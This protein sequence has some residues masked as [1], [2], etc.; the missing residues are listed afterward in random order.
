MNID[1]GQ[2]KAFATLT[3]S[4]QG[5]LYIEKLLR[6]IPRGGTVLEI[7][8]GNGALANMLQKEGYVVHA[9]DASPYC[10]D[11]LNAGIT[12]IKA[13]IDRELLT[14]RDGSLDA[15]VAFNVLEHL[16]YPQP[17][18]E[19]LRAKMKPSGVIYAATP[20]I[21]WW[22]FRIYFALGRCPEDLHTTDHVQ[23]WNLRHFR[24]LFEAAGW[25]VSE[26]STSLGLW[27]VFGL[28]R[29]FFKAGSA[30]NGGRYVFIA[31]PRP[32]PLLGYEQMIVAHT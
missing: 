26:Q 8:V 9:V 6:D 15:V 16:K 32:H 21:N 1:E 22:P 17:F 4:V 29:K 30:E 20:N 31:S 11:T 10:L 19:A 25:R 2:L 14:V 28:L 3:P 27:G 24:C 5:R 23:F 13:D 7:G 12:R 18:L